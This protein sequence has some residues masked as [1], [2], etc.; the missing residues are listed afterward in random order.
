MQSYDP[1][2]GTATACPSIARRAPRV[3]LAAGIAMMAAGP[4]TAFQFDLGPVK[5]SLIHI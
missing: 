2:Q 1:V 4:A 3:A 5:L